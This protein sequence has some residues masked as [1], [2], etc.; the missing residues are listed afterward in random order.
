MILLT[1]QPIDVTAV[2]A[3]VTTEASGAI[4]VFIGTTRNHSGGKAVRSLSYEAYPEMAEQEIA[5][6]VQEVHYH[7]PAHKIAVVHRLGDVP[8]GEAS[9]AIAVSSSHR[10]EAF[11][12]CR[13]IIDRLKERVP[14]WKKEIFEDGS[15]AWSGTPQKDSHG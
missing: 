10:K 7:W 14:I 11:E 2:V 13:F 9:V 8:L 15:G 12:A 1:H 4:D 6:I 3:A 5:R